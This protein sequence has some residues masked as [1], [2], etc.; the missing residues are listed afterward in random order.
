MSI[1]H[2]LFLNVFNE[3]LPLYLKFC[4]F[5]LSWLA[6]LIAL[7]APRS[8]SLCLTPT[9]SPSSKDDY[10]PGPLWWQSMASQ[11]HWIACWALSK[12]SLAQLSSPEEAQNKYEFWRWQ[13]AP[14]RKPDL[15]RSKYNYLRETRQHVRVHLGSYLSKLISCFKKRFSLNMSWDLSSFSHM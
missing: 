11:V 2:L 7:N 8:L 9:P 4:Q 13:T 5:F 1:P 12:A 14:H 6:V 15:L 10:T 3:K